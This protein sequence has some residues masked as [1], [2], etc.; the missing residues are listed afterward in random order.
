MKGMYPNKGVMVRVNDNPK[1]SSRQIM[2]A[3]PAVPK[4]S[5]RAR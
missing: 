1:A 3:M 5:N 2:C 4:V